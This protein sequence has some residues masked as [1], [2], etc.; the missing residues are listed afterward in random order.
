MRAKDVPNARKQSPD[1]TKYPTKQADTAKPAVSACFFYLW[2][3][4]WK[5]WNLYTPHP[6]NRFP[7]R[8][9]VGTRKVSFAVPFPYFSF[10]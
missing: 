7:H 5:V 6:W 4:V 10:K 9:L 8:P 1:T 3:Q 2:N